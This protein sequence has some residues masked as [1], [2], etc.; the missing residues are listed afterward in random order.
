M[1]GPREL[2]LGGM[3]E[4]MCPNVWV[5]KYFESVNIHHGQVSGPQEPLL[6]HG[7]EIETRMPASLGGMS[8]P[9]LPLS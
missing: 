4:G 5:K 9:L 1:A 2:K 8:H 6:G 3:I 7:Y